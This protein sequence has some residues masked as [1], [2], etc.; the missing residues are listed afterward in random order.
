MLEAVTSVRGLGMRLFHWWRRSPARPNS[1][2]ALAAEPFTEESIAIVPASRGMYQ[3][4]RDGEVIYAGMALSNLRRE[5]QSHRRGLLG[6][7]TRAASGFLYEVTAH[8]E[9]ALREYLRTYMVCNGARLPPCNV[10]RE[11]QAI[12]EEICNAEHGERLFRR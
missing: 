1:L 5:L 8:P 2:G 10:L 12:Q 9:E 4:Y 3:L 7:C 11:R 6:E